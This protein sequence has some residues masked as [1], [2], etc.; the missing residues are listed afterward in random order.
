MID[1]K[2]LIE[3]T[4]NMEDGF[5]IASGTDRLLADHWPLKHWKEDDFDLNKMLEIRIFNISQE[6]K[7]FR[8]DIASNFKIRT[9]TDEGDVFDEWQYLDIDTKQQIQSIDKGN[10]VQSTTGG[11]YF[12]PVSDI[13]VKTAIHIR[14]R[15]DYYPSGKAYVSDFRC[16][17]FGE[18]E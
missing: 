17:E 16:I 8:P 7:W 4:R 3:Q 11:K 13:S 6:V 15:I 5:I 9:M 18:K 10:M 2:M 12:I 1:I 14:C